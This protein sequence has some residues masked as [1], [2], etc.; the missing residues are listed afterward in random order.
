MEYR[1]GVA[2]ETSAPVTSGTLATQTHY[3]SG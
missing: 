1:D 2:A 3:K